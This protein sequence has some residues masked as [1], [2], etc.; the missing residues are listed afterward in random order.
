MRSSTNNCWS[1]SWRATLPMV[2]C[3][4]SWFFLTCWI[5]ARRLASSSYGLLLST[6]LLRVEHVNAK[7]QMYW[8]QRN[9]TERKQIVR[10]SDFHL[11]RSGFNLCSKLL[12]GDY[13]QFNTKKQCRFSPET[14]YSSV[15]TKS[16]KIGEM[17]KHLHAGHYIRWRHNLNKTITC[18]SYY[19]PN[20]LCLKDIFPGILW[21]GMIL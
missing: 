19:G 10:L 20:N 14:P 9:I 4:L 5:S 2:F 7:R 11:S 15:V 18:M 6:G 1:I 21:S 17:Y 16:G 12:S 13:F 3:R 8:I